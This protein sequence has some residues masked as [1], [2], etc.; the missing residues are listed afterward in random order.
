ML[1][2]RPKLFR[3]DLIHHIATLNDARDYLEIGIHD[4]AC[5]QRL[6]LANITGVDPNPLAAGKRWCTRFYPFTSDIYFKA[7]KNEKFDIIFID[8]LH[9]GEQVTKDINNS[10][11]RLNPEGAIVLHDMNPSEEWRER[12]DTNGDCWRAIYRVRTTNPDVIAFTI[13]ADQGLGVILP[14]PNA[15][16]SCP[17]KMP[18][19]LNYSVLAKDREKVIGLVGIEAGLRKINEY[20]G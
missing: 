6:H 14:K 15:G 9:T 10:L 13:D 5:L 1:K 3:Y 12:P 17:E 4:G 16:F 20:Y 7:I 2:P 18:D 11:K 8:G 19:V